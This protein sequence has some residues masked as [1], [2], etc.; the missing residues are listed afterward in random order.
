MYIHISPINLIC[1][2]TFATSEDVLNYFM[3]I[4]QKKTNVIYII[5][6]YTYMTTYPNELT[7][8]FGPTL[9]TEHTCMAEVV[10]GLNWI[11]YINV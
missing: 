4:K 9:V 8:A 6:I 10:I 3:Y 1:V 7:I 5:T 2:L 11:I